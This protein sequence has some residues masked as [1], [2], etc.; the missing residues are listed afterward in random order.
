MSVFDFLELIL[1]FLALF[2]AH[3]F[4]QKS[5]RFLH[6]LQRFCLEIIS[7]A[8]RHLPQPLKDRHPKID[9]VAVRDSGNMYRHA[10]EF[11]TDQRLWDTLTKHLDLLDAAVRQEL[12][13]PV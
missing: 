7:E 1:V 10:Y 3:V 13:K 4:G 2:G 5:H 12:D 8:S 9:W 6:R 11:V